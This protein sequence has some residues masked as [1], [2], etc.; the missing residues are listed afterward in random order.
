MASIV[1]WI[2]VVLVNIELSYRPV[3]WP[4]I[5]GSNPPQKLVMM[6]LGREGNNNHVPV[7]S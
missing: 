5:S 1:I 7:N 6:N 4:R 2:V 3:N